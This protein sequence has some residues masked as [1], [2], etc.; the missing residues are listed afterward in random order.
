MKV[1]NFLTVA[2]EIAVLYVKMTAM[3]FYCIYKFFVPDEPKSV[4]GEIILVSFT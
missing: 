3:W 4:K 2:L 1:Y